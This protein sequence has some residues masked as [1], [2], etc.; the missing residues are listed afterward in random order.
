MIIWNDIKKG[1]LPPHKEEVLWLN[2]MEFGKLDCETGIVHMDSNTGWW[3][4]LAYGFDQP[5]TLGSTRLP[6]DV[7]RFWTEVNFPSDEDME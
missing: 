2:S 5:V 7:V 3:Y 1:K 6:L 4:D